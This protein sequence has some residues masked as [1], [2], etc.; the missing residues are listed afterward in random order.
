M[1]PNNIEAKKMDVLDIIFI[2]RNKAYGA[3][4]LRRIYPKHIKKSLLWGVLI[5]AFFLTLPMWISMLNLGKKDDEKLDEVKVDLK[6]I[7][8]KKPEEKKPL[9]PPP[10]P[11]KEPPK[12]PSQKFTPPVIKK[13]EE[14]K[15]EPPKVEDITVNTATETVKSDNTKYVPQEPPKVET[16]PVEDNDNKV[17]EFVEQVPAFPGGQEALFSYLQK[18]IKYPPIA[19]ENG[20]EG[21]VFLSFVVD[22][23][24]QIRDIKVKRGIGGGCDEEAVRVVRNMPQWKPGRQNGKEVNV[25]FT[26][27]IKFTLQ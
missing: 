20:I 5:F 11:K 25:M 9:P 1:E 27:P 24:G 19:R 3:Y 6:K 22:K 18:N 2:G 13:D 16:A 10:P 4:F 8:T 17:F 12:P 23:S 21:K 14:V 15:K 26:L 7:E